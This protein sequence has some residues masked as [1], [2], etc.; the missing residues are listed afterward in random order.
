MRAPKPDLSAINPLSLP[1]QLRML[2]RV[3]G[4]SA[5][6]KLVEQ[7]GGSYVI[8]PKRFVPEHDL[9]EIL[10]TQA[11]MAL[12]DACGSET[13][14]L[15]KYDSVLRQIRHQRVMELIGKGY[16]LREVALKVNY[17]VRQVIN[18]KQANEVREMQG[19][20]W[21]MFPDQGEVVEIED[22][23]ADNLPTAHN[24]FG[25]RYTPGDK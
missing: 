17:T 8:V 20:L 22:E 21:D 24:P 9:H 5:A 15:P 16:L 25:M 13:L 1:P 7:R 11:F 2:M 6:Y 3:L 10:G 23:P 12:I 14:Q 19:S 18:I 4:E